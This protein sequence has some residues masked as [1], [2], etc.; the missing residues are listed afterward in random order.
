MKKLYFS[1]LLALL[2]FFSCISGDLFAQ[3]NP[4]PQSIPYFQNFS[5]LAANSTTYPAGFQGWNAST[6]SSSSL[7]TPSNFTTT[8]TSD[9]ALTAG[10]SAGSTGGNVYN[11]SGKIGFLNA[12]SFLDQAI[13]LALN[14]TGNTNIQVKYD[15]MVIRNPVGIGS[16]PS[17]RINQFALQY[18][19]GTSGAFNTLSS[20]AYENTLA[21]QKIDAGD[22][23]S[24]DNKIIKV[25]LPAECDNQPV[26]Q[27]RWISRQLSGSGSRPSFAI[28]NIEIEKDIYA[29]ANVLGYPKTANVLGVSFDFINKIDEVGKTYYVLLPGGSAE[30][31][32]AQIKAGQDSNGTLA[33]QSGVFDVTNPTQEYIKSFAGLTLNTTYSVFSISE[34]PYNNLQTSVSKTDVTTLNVM[35]PAISP[36]VAILNLG[37]TE[38]NYDPL[39][40]SYQIGASDLTANVVVT[41]SG[42]FTIS[43]DNTSF[44]SIL[45][46]VPADFDSNATPTVYVKF[47]P[48]SVGSFTG[49]ITHETTGGTTKTVNLTAL[50][51]N[52]FVQNFDD[53]NVFA[54]SKWSQYNEAG[55]INKWAYTNQPRNVNS[56]TGAVLMNG[57][58]DSGA[59]KDWLISPRLRLDGFTQI[60]LLSFYSRQFYDGPSLKLMVSTNYDGVSDPNTATWT[61]INGRFPQETGSYVKSE[62]INLSAYKTDHTYLAWVY[63]TT[64]GGNG[65]AAEWSFDDFAII[66]ESKYVDSNPRLDFADVSPNSVSASQTFVFA[67]AGYGDITIEAPASYELSLDNISFASNIV[68]SSA[69]ALTGKTI[70]ARFAP[71]TKEPTVSGVL[72]VTGTSLNKEIGSF[73][74]TSILKADTYDVVTYNLE[75]FGTDVKDKTGKEFGPTNDVLQIENVAKVMNKLNADVYVVQEVSDEQALDALI[76]KISING[77]TFDKT[78]STSW[79]YSFK[80]LDPNFPPQK[81]VVLY[82]TQTTTVK[83]TKVL[84]KDLY[85]QIRFNTVVLPGY[86]GSETPEI[87]D[88]SF[89]SSGRLPYL[90]QVEAN[91]GGIKKEINLIDL[92]ARANSGTD[93]SKYNQRK[94]DID[95]LKD[96]LDAEYPD[97][98]LILLGDFND[99]VKAWVGNASTASSYKKFVDDT[100]NYNALTWDI[101]QAGAYSFL[102]SQGFLDHILISNEL[103]DDYI[104]KSIAVY[105]PRNDIANYTTT[106][107]DHGPVIARFE[108]KQDV[109]STPDFGKNQYFVKAYP[110]PAADVLNFDVKTTQGRDLKIRLYD[111]NGRAIGNPISVKNESEVSTAVVAVG[112]LVSGVYFYTVTENNKVI[113]K[114]KV[115]KK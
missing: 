56:G 52:P 24:Q 79:S 78:I 2:C 111:F 110:N 26:V 11:F 37:G 87:N 10:G 3:T 23:S 15:A 51:V 30:P 76:Q 61:P 75:F 4:T 92:H 88:D 29:P 16:P 13:V 102:S 106:T 108:L 19:V 57:F 74:G 80:D 109:L 59:S 39:I 83:S 8:V 47:T 81:L 60:P 67:A 58:S 70:Y 18:R 54:N 91:I 100:T 17:S 43:K 44:S 95:Y 27:I 65:N 66:D 21:Q 1:R 96:A 69:D 99:D 6:P 20:T 85:D 12:G 49:T 55:P 36:S 35:P 22:V 84:F 34:D 63:E 32:V 73:T 113:F 82:N 41:A 98:N 46:F 33:L 112:N 89:F 114:D 48:T 5:G 104:D 14:T 115:I 103:N 86:P 77:K 68:V 62:Y 53:A 28:D 42:N 64:S 71:T 40:K 93:I 50:G 31:T 101:S 107:S 7:G 38:P 72:K 105:D 94:Y 9:K 25:T 45:S 90:V 97:A